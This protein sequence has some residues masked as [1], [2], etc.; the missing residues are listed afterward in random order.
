MTVFYFLSLPRVLLSF[1]RK[2]LTAGP[3]VALC[4]KA[5]SVISFIRFLILVLSS[6]S[7]ENVLSTSAVWIGIT[8]Q[9][10]A[11]MVMLGYIH[12]S[13]KSQQRLDT[14]SVCLGGNSYLLETV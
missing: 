3:S 14:T 7:S 11:S 8:R 6:L 2:L 4:N 13:D 12:A 10:L 5:S 1:T 9:I